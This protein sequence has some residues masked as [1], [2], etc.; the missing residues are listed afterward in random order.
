MS[1]SCSGTQG[2][3]TL[4]PL[5][6]LSPTETNTSVA[7]I[8]TPLDFT[9]TNLP[10]FTKIPTITPTPTQTSTP[11]PIR[12]PTKTP[13]PTTEAQVTI[14]AFGPFCNGR[15]Y[16]SEV[17]PNGQW[18]TVE[19]VGTLD[20]PDTHLRVVSIDRSKDWKIYFG[21]Y[22]EGSLYDHKDGIYPYR[23]SKDGRF[24]YA[25]APTRFEGCCWIGGYGLLVRL[26]LETGDQVDI[27][28]VIDT[29][30]SLGIPA[31]SFA[32]L[33][34]DRYLVY[35]H[36]LSDDKFVIQDL[37]TW[38]TQEIAIKFQ[39]DIDANYVLLSSDLDKIVLALFRYDE[40]GEDHFPLD[41]IGLINLK[42]GEQKKLISNIT[43]DKPLYP[44]R[45]EDADHVLLSTTR[46]YRWDDLPP[47][48][49][50]WLLNIQTAELTKIENP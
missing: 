39:N 43:P 36:P 8:D 1:V 12:T 31:I 25:V 50:F 42:T 48:N 18:I 24:L 46:R 3:E 49:E 2:V 9:P 4:S 10:T 41:A 35:V 40:D 37:L 23:W 33:D 17:S 7:I 28:N 29:R 20:N 6:T 34:D 30:D 26:N 13:F 11:L 15:A 22:A 45:W 27:L 16:D 47:E 19:C 21:D 14:D 32:I 44:V 5:S 38:E